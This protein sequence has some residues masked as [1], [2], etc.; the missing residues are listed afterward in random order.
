MAL[1]TFYEKLFMEVLNSSVMEYKNICRGKN[2]NRIMEPINILN[3][4]TIGKEKTVG[5]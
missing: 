2:S 5:Y 1:V 4:I 3:N